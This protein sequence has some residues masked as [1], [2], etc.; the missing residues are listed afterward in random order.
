MTK[1]LVMLSTYNGEQYLSQLLDSVLAQVGVEVSIVV[2]DDGSK[3]NT[4]AILA[5]YAQKAPLTFEAGTNM[6][7]RNSFM[8]L[9]K[10][11][12]M[13][14]D[15]DYYALADQDDIWLPDKLQ[16]A[17]AKLQQTTGPA[18][19]HSNVTLTDASGA[20]LGSRYPET[21][22]S[23]QH[24][25]EN[26]FD[27]DWLGTTMVFDRDL[28]TLVQH[29]APVD[30]LVHD[31]YVIAVA[32]FLGTVIYD[33]IPHL[34][35]RRSENSVTGFGDSKKTQQIKKPSL[36]DRYKRYKKNPFIHP[37]SKRAQALLAGYGEQLT[38]PQR[39]FL[40]AVANYRTSF[41][42][43]MRLLFDP[44]IKASNLRQ[45]LQIKYRVLANT[46]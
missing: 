16:V 11:V 35:Y 39:Q 23:T 32:Q 12:E 22:L 26:F 17:I 33:P 24:C 9:L 27:V 14:A 38:A 43:R 40:S 29:H 30:Q 34:L 2:R 42:A 46:L 15:V 28:M 20:Q 41:G 37:F 10:T 19:Y 25:P 8:T 18:L 31:A 4:R 7:W 3:D 13:P 5:D 45:T 44:R 21:Y 36:I 1:V 6:G